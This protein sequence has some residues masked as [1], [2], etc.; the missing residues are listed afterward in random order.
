MRSH[1]SPALSVAVMSSVLVT[2]PRSS[3][4]LAGHGQCWE[5]D[6]TC[7]VH[8]GLYTSPLPGSSALGW[9]CGARLNESP[10]VLPNSERMQL[11]LDSLN[12]LTAPTN[13]RKRG[14]RTSQ[15]PPLRFIY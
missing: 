2:S 12:T 4:R 9:V 11:S 3:S 1:P 14:G 5:R 7:G 10:S 8:D 15:R 6:D 13:P